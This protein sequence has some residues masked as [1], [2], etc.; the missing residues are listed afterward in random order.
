MS[1][2]I[3]DLDRSRCMRM[4]MERFRMPC[5]SMPSSAAASQAHRQSWGCPTMLSRRRMI[6]LRSASGGLAERC[7]ALQCCRICSEVRSI[8]MQNP[9]HSCLPYAHA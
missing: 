9:V 1:R 4:A 5:K 8:I 7:P 2:S 6:L 3:S